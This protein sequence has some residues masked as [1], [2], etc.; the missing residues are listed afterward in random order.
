MYDK[1]L[2]DQITGLIR[3]NGRV[4]HPVGE[5]DDM[6]IAWLLNHWLITQAKNLSYYGIDP[7][8]VGSLAHTTGVD[9]DPQHRTEQLEQ[10]NIRTSL[11]ALAERLA[12]AKDGFLITRLEQEIRQLSRKV[13]LEENELF[14][15][16][17]LIKEA[18]EKKRLDRANGGVSNQSVNRFKQGSSWSGANSGGTQIGRFR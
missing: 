16:D 7:A 9:A 11:K 5:H 13:V 6:C 12:S 14:N 15:I 17:S 10:R 4:N 3:K 1:T 8:L 18:K 2:A